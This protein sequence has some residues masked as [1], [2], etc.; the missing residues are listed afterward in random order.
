MIKIFLFYLF[1]STTM[2]LHSTLNI[3]TNI[4]EYLNI[5]ISAYGLIKEYVLV[6]LLIYSLQSLESNS[7]FPIN[8]NSS[9]LCIHWGTYSLFF[10]LVTW[11]TNETWKINS[12]W[13]PWLNPF[14]LKDFIGTITKLD[15]VWVFDSNLFINVI[16]Y[17]FF[18]P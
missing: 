17:Y 13:Y 10:F 11:E 14:S 15:E 6:A 3:N 18:W 12:T 7:N 1:A 8:N 4:N 16:F 2:L 9:I 5:F